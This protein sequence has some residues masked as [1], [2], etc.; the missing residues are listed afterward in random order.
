[1]KN[2]RVFFELFGKKMQ[3]VVLAI[4]EN[5]AKEVIKNKIKFFEIREENKT[6][7]LDDFLN[8]FKNIK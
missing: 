4:N 1:M 5:S 8:I 7:N 3:A 6:S 2:Y